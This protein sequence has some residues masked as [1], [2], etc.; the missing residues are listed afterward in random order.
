[1]RHAGLIDMG[2]NAIRTEIIEFDEHGSR[3]MDK[4]RT[5]IRLGDD[6]FSTGAIS[7]ENIRRAVHSMREFRVA[8]DGYRV[9][10]IR[11]VATSAVREASNGPEFLERLRLD[12]GVEIHAITGDTEAE[13]LHCAVQTRV[14]TSHGSFLLVDLGGGSVELVRVRDGKVLAAKSFACG[15]VR[16]LNQID[17][18]ADELTGDGLTSAI[19]AAYE[20]IESTMRRD[21][22]GVTDHCIAVGGNI[23]TIVELV[24]LEHELGAELDVLSCT[25]AQIE[26]ITGKLA[27]LPQLERMTRFGLRPDRADTIVPAGIVYASVAAIAGTTHLAVP[28]VGIR[29][30]IRERTIEELLAADES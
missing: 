19:R 11:G 4:R 13:F 5:P 17:R 2:S 30:G 8:C 16:L 6:V 20:P 1:L 24:A 12:A 7:E 18:H 14:D 10:A 29:S 9:D 25:V 22:G 23:E 15:A 28:R 21:F 27:A 26:E 3:T